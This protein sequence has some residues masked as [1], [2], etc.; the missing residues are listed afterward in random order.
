MKDYSMISEVVVT[1]SSEEANLL[2][3]DHWRLLDLYHDGEGVLLFV[4]GDTRPQ[5]MK[6]FLRSQ[7]VAS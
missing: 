5:E 4:L 2:L 6:D 3:E 1:P 7:E